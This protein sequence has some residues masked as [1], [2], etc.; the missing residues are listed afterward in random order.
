MRRWLPALLILGLARPLLAA[1]IPGS[2]DHL[3]VPRYAGSEILGYEA[4]VFEAA[5]LV[6]KPIGRGPIEAA[7]ATAQGAVTRIRYLAPPGRSGIELYR[8]YRNALQEAGFRIVYACEEAACGPI[9]TLTGWDRRGTSTPRYLAAERAADGMKVAVFVAGELVPSS[10]KGRSGYEVLVVEPRQMEQKVAV[11]RATAMAGDMAATG[12]VQLYA[13]QFDTDRATLR[14]ESQEQLKEIA[15]FIASQRGNF[16]VVGHT[17]MTGAFE[18]NQ[19]LSAERAAAVVAALSS[20]HGVAR[21][22]L[23]PVGVGPAAPVASNRTPEGRARNRRVEV[24]E[25]P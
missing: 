23:T 11:V 15:A 18:R 21:S 4:K 7:T 24:V 14:P 10:F 6:V 19:T 13:I 25:Q 5:R 20:R 16:L 22:R 8:N 12:R 3:V 9:Q 1:D 17:D 2:R